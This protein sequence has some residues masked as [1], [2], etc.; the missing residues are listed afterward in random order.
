[1]IACALYARAA[2]TIG[3][4]YYYTQTAVWRC[5][6]LLT[7]LS[8][9]R[10]PLQLLVCCFRGTSWNVSGTDYFA[11]ADPPR[12]GLGSTTHYFKLPGTLLLTP[13]KALE[14]HPQRKHPSLLRDTCHA[15]L[16]ISSG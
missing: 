9:E 13:P 16:D 4:R 5:L 14:R 7:A 11:E 1:M 2:I 15:L 12:A 6:C 8:V 10:A 3:G